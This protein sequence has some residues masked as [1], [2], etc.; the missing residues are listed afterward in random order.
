MLGGWGLTD[1]KSYDAVST[2]LSCKTFD[3]R[4]HSICIWFRNEP[5]FYGIYKFSFYRRLCPWRATLALGLSSQQVNTLCQDLDRSPVLSE[6]SKILVIILWEWVEAAEKA[7]R[8]L[9]F[10]DFLLLVRFCLF[11]FFLFIA[12]S[13]SLNCMSLGKSGWAVRLGDAVNGQSQMLW[14]LP[15]WRGTGLCPVQ[16]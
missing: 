5:F 4:L 6:G 16:R 7:N 11:F 13:I 10:G 9:K 14:L 15:V 3:K 8:V 12:E 2:K 1:E